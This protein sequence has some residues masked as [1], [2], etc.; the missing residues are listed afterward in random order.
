MPRQFPLLDGPLQVSKDAS[1]QPTNRRQWCW[2]RENASNSATLLLVFD[3]PLHD[4]VDGV[5]RLLRGQ[6]VVVGHDGEDDVLALLRGRVAGERKHVRQRA[7]LGVNASS[8]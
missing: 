8:R 3:H 1:K 2:V 4:L 6:V 7:C 5:E